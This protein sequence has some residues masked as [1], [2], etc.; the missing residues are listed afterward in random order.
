MP[1]PNIVILSVAPLRADHLSCYGY[2]RDTSPRVDALAAEG[3]LF[4]RA[5]TT[6]AWTP[7]TIGSLLT[8]L[9]PSSHGVAERSGLAP[10]VRTLPQ[11]LAAAGYHTVGFSTTRMIGQLKRLDRGFIDFREPWSKR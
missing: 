7:P 4:E 9:Y 1:P 3:A 8:G 2:G 11:V 10:G 6:G 5:S